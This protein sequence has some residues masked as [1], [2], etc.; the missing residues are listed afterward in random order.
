MQQTGPV[1]QE[2]LLA[3][4][5]GQVCKNPEGYHAVHLPLSRL[6]AHNRRDHHIRIAANSLEPLVDRSNGA[7]FVLSNKDIVAAFR[8]ITVSEVDEVV[9]KLRFLFSEDPLANEA[10]GEPNQD[11]R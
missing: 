1:D 4:F 3:E 2:A 5:A 11:D 8:D 10:D 6:K 7:L 9:V